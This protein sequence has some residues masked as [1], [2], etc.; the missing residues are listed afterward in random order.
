MKF[1]AAVAYHFCLNLPPTFSQPRTNIISGSNAH[2][3]AIFS[4]V[5]LPPCLCSGH[6]TV[7]LR[8]GAPHPHNRTRPT[9]WVKA[10]STGIYGPKPVGPFSITVLHGAWQNVK[11]KRVH[12]GRFATLSWAASCMHLASQWEFITTFLPSPHNTHLCLNAQVELHRSRR[13]S[14]TRG[15]IV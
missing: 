14:T 2:T 15:R 11:I 3:S 6:S 10:F 9:E 7:R 4:H 5:L 1:V 8:S 12:L 13:S